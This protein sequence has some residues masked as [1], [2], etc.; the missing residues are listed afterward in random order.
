MFNLYKI[1][2]NFSY[3]LIIFLVVTAIRG[4]MTVRS[5]VIVRGSVAVTAM[6]VATVGLELDGVRFDDVINLLVTDRFVVVTS[7]DGVQIVL[8][9][10]DSNSIKMSHKYASRRD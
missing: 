4:S 10:Y 3:E 5:L 9:K 8:T 1:Q 7:V 6:T 2:F